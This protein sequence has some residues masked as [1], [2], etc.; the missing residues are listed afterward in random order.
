MLLFSGAGSP[1]HRAA[2]GVAVEMGCGAGSTGTPA[3]LTR[4]KPHPDFHRERRGP[5]LQSSGLVL[6]TGA[7]G[8]GYRT[9]SSNQ[10]HRD[11]PPG[12]MGV[13]RQAGGPPLAQPLGSASAA[14]PWDIHLPPSQLSRPLAEP[15]YKG[16]PERSEVSS[17]ARALWCQW[18]RAGVCRPLPMV[19]MLTTHS[20]EGQMG[21]SSP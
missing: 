18:R 10:P 14:G 12:L 8:F 2:P 19:R 5:R 21:V 3:G 9:L 1:A 15:H 4:G 11:P 13:R 17:A 7:S 6:A 16:F 20:V